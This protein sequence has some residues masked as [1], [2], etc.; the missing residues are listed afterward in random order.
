M[1]QVALEY[2]GI[3]CSRLAGVFA[4]SGRLSGILSCQLAFGLLIAWLEDWSL[5]DGVYLA[6]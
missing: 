3:S 2:D 5:G 6:S 1:P 4:L